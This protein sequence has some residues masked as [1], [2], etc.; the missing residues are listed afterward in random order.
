MVFGFGIL[1][2]DTGLNRDNN[3]R[4]VTHLIALLTGFDG[5]CSAGEAVQPNG[6]GVNEKIQQ[7]PG[8]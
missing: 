7:F 4:Y 2:N 5:I 6:H 8:V 1:R 3:E